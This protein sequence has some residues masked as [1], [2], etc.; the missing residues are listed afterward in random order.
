MENDIKFS[1]YRKFVS[2]DIMNKMN[3]FKVSCNL[4]LDLNLKARKRLLS[5]GMGWYSELR[6]RIRIYGKEDVCSIKAS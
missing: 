4:E 5:C 2:L 3:R 6:I 1:Y